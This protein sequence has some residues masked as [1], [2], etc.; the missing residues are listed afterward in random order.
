MGREAVCQCD[1]A[2][3]TAE[4]KVLLE[5]GEIILRGGIRKRVPLDALLDV[6]VLAD[7]L[8]FIVGREPV[9]LFLGSAAA[10][11]WAKAIATPPPALSRKLGIT[12][13]SIVRTIGSIEDD[14]LKAALAEA[15]RIS[16]RDADLIVAYVDSPKSL[17]ATL[18]KAKPQV[19]R[20]VP[21]WMVYAKGPGHPLNESLIRSLLRANEMIDTKVASVSAKLTALRFCHRQPNE[22]R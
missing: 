17:S 1:W 22:D 21:I 14:A 12:G 13:K 6:R 11:R 10:V 19:V 18:E 15:A 3:T 2:G 16:A 4:V 7:R 5:P 20:G 9:Q 8:C